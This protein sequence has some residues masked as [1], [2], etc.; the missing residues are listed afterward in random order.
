MRFPS[1]GG[2]WSIPKA[3]SVC[4]KGCVSGVRGKGLPGLL[5]SAALSGLT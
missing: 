5:L 4:A 3:A 2:K 1:H